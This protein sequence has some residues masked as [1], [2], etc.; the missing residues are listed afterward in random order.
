MSGGWCRPVAETSVEA[1]SQNTSCGLAR[2]LGF[3]QQVS[4]KSQTELPRVL[5]PEVTLHHLC[6]GPRARRFK[7]GNRAHLFGGEW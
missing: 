5:A 7:G 6:S 3:P 2:W 4:Q 1:V